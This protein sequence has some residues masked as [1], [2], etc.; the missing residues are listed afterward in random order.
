MAEQQGVSGKTVTTLYYFKG[1]CEW[2]V[3]AVS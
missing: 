1:N 3:G 2:S